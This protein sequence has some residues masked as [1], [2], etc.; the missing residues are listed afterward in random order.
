MPLFTLENSHLKVSIKSLGAE[1]SSLFD[2]NTQIEHVWQADPKVWGRH[3]PVL[4]PIVGKLENDTYHVGERE[5]KLLQHG[6]ARNEEFVVEK[7]TADAVT[8]LLKSNERS[9]TIYP[10]QFEL[11]LIYLLVGRRLTIGYEVTNTDTQ[12]IWFSIGGHPGFTCPFETGAKFD[13]YTLEFEKPE[14]AT[15]I[16][17]GS[18][19]LTG[20]KI[21]H[22]LNED[23]QIKVSHEVFANDAIILEGLQSKYVDLKR[24]GGSRA[25]RFYFEGFPL[26]A[27]WTHPENKAD[28]L[29]IEPWFGIA[30]V[31]GSNK[32]YREK[33]FIQQ[34]EVGK[35]FS[36]AYAV[37]VLN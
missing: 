19:L 33:D 2:K 8:F 14:T 11:R 20:Q 28:Y 27:F 10:Y 1:L 15:K 6:F 13:D 18:G 32:D 5:Y 21:P 35:V 36:C 22:F 23:Q 3:A 12:N 34:L 30:D 9:L 16:V 37:E 25:L 26:L 7:Q 24:E 31:K 29:C 17:F 4:F